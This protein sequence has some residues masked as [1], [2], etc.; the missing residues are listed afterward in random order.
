MIIQTL[1]HLS[2]HQYVFAEDA[3]Q[4][5]NTAK[6]TALIRGLFG[7]AL[8]VIAFGF[9]SHARRGKLAELVVG[10]ICLVLCA[11]VIINPNI[12]FNA[13]AGLGSLFA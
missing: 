4:I 3:P 11:M 10:I 2:S 7:L 8:A 13:A 5:I 1:Q 12:I 6:A 9:L